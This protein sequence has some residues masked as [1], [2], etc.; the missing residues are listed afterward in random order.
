VRPWRR[1]LGPDGLGWAV[2]TNHAVIA[3]GP[4]AP[5]PQACADAMVWSVNLT[6]VAIT[7]AGRAWVVG[8]DGMRAR[9]P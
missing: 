5:A 6:A 4:D 1:S 8:S 3:L 2:G 7:P 9:T